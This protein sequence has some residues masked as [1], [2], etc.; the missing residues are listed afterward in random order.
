VPGK[1]ARHSPWAVHYPKFRNQL[2]HKKHK[3]RKGRGLDNT[4]DFNGFT[5]RVK[6]DKFV[7]DRSSV[8]PSEATSAIRGFNCVF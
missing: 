4:G 3:K 8:F 2:G 5:C 1:I 6:P 7:F